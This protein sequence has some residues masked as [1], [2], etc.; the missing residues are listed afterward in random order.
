MS[1][2]IYKFERLLTESLLHDIMALILS[3]KIKRSISAYKETNEYKELEAEIKKSS[4]R[5][6]TISKRLEQL[7][8]E[9]QS[10]IDQLN[11]M[12]VDVK[13]SMSPTEM[14]NKYTEWSKKLHSDT[15]KQIA[16]LN[17]AKKYIK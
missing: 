9:R 11:K 16:Q 8:K 13:L 17:K 2:K 4:D 10:N 5:L 6:T 1:N 12:G 7:H 15:K 14:Y 3:P